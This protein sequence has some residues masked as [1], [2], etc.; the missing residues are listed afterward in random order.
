M[1]IRFQPLYKSWIS[2]N[3]KGLRYGSDPWIVTA[4]TAT[5]NLPSS[6]TVKSWSPACPTAALQNGDYTFPVTHT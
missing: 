3:D 2:G 5:D 6:L 4:V 1:T